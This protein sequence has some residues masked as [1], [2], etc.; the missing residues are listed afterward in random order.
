MF[1]ADQAWEF[2]GLQLDL[3][4]RTLHGRRGEELML[5]RSEYELLLAFIT[6]PGRALSRDFLLQAVARRRSEPYDR[7]I[8]VLVGRLRRKIELDL[9]QPRLILTVPG[10]GYR[11]AIKPHS[12]PPPADGR[13]AVRRPVEFS[14]HDRRQSVIVLPFENRGGDPAQDGLAARMTRDVTDLIAG[15]HTVPLIPAATAAAYGGK[16]LDLHV[17]GREHNVHFALMGNARRQDER[18]IVSA[19]LYETVDDRTVWSRRFDVSDRPDAWK[20][21]IQAIYGG[22][23]QA[24]NDVEAARA[25]RERPDSLDQRDLLFLAN[26]TSLSPLT[27]ENN[28]AKI[29]L[30]ERALAIDPNYVRALR[31]YARGRANLV[32]DG[33]S[34]DPDADLSAAS[35]VI[36]RALLIAPNDVGSRVEKANVLRAQGNWGEAA[37]LLRKVIEIVPLQAMRYR[38]L[39]WILMV[40]GHFKE[41][42]ENFL[43]ANQLATGSGDIGV[44]PLIESNIALALLAN[45]RLPEAI[46]QAQLAIATYPP[47]SGRNAEHPWLTLIAAESANGQDAEAQAE[48]RKYLAIPRELRTI[49][50]V[51]KLPY[52]ANAPK[53]LL[54]GLRRAG[55]P[56]E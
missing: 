19:T 6:H 12:R 49:A 42:L 24:T 22:F 21:I 48:L 2:E 53:L 4:A 44:I 16:P 39:G 1:A 38:E 35:R 37:A 3:S 54:E 13:T 27:K 31:S 29:A 55:M 18:L 34:S 8:D 47:E 23:G 25:M 10:V 30:L 7:S 11:F 41:A 46:A 9:K 28:L 52:F 45:D 14:P 43:T 50:A 20:S 36:D 17:I 5:R 51:Q 56:A 33:W 15:D 26:T 40:Q 32:L